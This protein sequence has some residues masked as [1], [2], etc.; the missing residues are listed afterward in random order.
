MKSSITLALGLMLGAASTRA[1]AQRQDMDH[2]SH[3][4]EPARLPT[5]AGQD[6][7]GAIAE[8]VRLLE[9]DPATDW[10]R[11]NLERLRIHLIAMNEVTLNASVAQSPVTAGLQMDVTGSGRT[12][13]AIRSMVRSH[14]AAL[15]RMQLWRA[16]LDE[17]PNGA[18]LTLVAVDSTDQRLIARI[19]G[20][21]FIGLLTV[22]DHHAPHHLALARGVSV[23]GH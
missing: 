7:Y 14:S 12:L 8:I 1:V 9:A 18:R 2:A 6:A 17:L 21:G 20:L 3:A 13:D 5:L 4:A 10:S 15:N 22:D 23:A 16:Q 19:R 11:V